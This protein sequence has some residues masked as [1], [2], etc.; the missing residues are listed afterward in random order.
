MNRLLQTAELAEAKGIR[1]EVVD[2]QLGTPGNQEVFTLP[3]TNIFAP[4][5]GWLEY[6]LVSFW[7]GLFSGAFAVSFLP[8]GGFVCLLVIFRLSHL[9]HHLISIVVP[10]QF[11]LLIPDTQLPIRIIANVALN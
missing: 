11:S 3:E 8:G 7:D 2:L 4:E 1:C 9:H 5:N 10:S 6:F